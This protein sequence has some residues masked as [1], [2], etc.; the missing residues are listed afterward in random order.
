MVT[1]DMSIL[2]SRRWQISQLFAK[3]LGWDTFSFWNYREKFRHPKKTEKGDCFAT[4]HKND[5]SRNAQDFT[6]PKIILWKKGVGQC[7]WISMNAQMQR[8]IWIIHPVDCI[9]SWLYN[10][11]NSNRIIVESTEQSR[12]INR[13]H[14]RQKRLCSQD[15]QMR[16]V[17]KE[18]KS[19]Q[20]R[21]W[22]ESKKPEVW[23]CGVG[24]NSPVRAEGDSHNYK[25]LPLQFF[26]MLWEHISLSIFW[27]TIITSD[28]K[29]V[30]KTAKKLRT[31]IVNSNFLSF[32]NSTNTLLLKNWVLLLP[33]I[34]TKSMQETRCFLENFT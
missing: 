13:W 32:F 6:F 28:K 15:S 27:E 26:I 10:F 3:F 19:L 5:W 33:K 7:T 2:T 25:F 31:N 34:W 16:N 20:V 8:K 21:R 17:R 12:R 18:E 14:V 4:F 29:F 22:E 23:I 9:S 1:T 24:D 11:T 30:K